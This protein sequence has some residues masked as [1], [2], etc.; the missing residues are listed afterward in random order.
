MSDSTQD[1]EDDAVK[2]LSQYLDQVAK[3][4]PPI[5]DVISDAVDKAIA[6]IPQYRVDEAL[7]QDLID[8]TK[9]RPDLPELQYN[10]QSPF[11]TEFKPFAYGGKWS[12]DMAAKQA[13]AEDILNK[14]AKTIV[15]PL[16]PHA[17]GTLTMQV[18]GEFISANQDLPEVLANLALPDAIRRAETLK[19]E[20][21]DAERR[22]K[23][24]LEAKVK[25]IALVEARVREHVLMTGASYMASDHMK[26]SYVK[27]AETVK[28]NTDKLMGF[29][30]ALSPDQKAGLLA[31]RTVEPK[32]ASTTLTYK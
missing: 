12:D 17:G 22:L 5:P 26:V 10:P 32:P 23:D 18:E 6:G 28:W 11:V 1:N 20:V 3:T 8:A 7:R 31:C 15:P 9:G 13:Q 25:A 16:H 29:A 27:P 21:V 2:R 19:A 30:A 24:F 4:P 14:L